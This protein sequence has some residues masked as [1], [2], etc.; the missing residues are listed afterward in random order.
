MSL[1]DFMFRQYT[2]HSLKEAVSSFLNRQKILFAYEYCLIC[3][4]KCL[5]F[6]NKQDLTMSPKNLLTWQTN[7]SQQ[8]NSVA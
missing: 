4:N 8:Y 5:I 6:I 7:I 1:T 2:V 3:Y